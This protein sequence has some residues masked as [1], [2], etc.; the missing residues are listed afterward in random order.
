MFSSL[1]SKLS[2]GIIKPI[3]ISQS[4]TCDIIELQSSSQEEKMFIDYLESANQIDARLL[5]TFGSP[6]RPHISIEKQNEIMEIMSDFAGHKPPFKIVHASTIVDLIKILSE[7]DFVADTQLGA[8]TCDL[9][10]IFVKFVVVLHIV[11]K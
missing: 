9:T 2:I 11:R 7:D 4:I 10:I 5:L 3:I 1:F 8:R 6:S